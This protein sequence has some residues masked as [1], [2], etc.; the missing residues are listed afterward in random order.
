MNSK[1]VISLILCFIYILILSTESS[2]QVTEVKYMVKF[3]ESTELYDCYVVII[4]GFATT[5]QHRTQMSSQYSVVV[6]TGSIVT[7]PQTYLPLQ[8][9]QNYGGTVPSLWSLANQIL[10][11]AVQP[12]SDFYGIAP[13][14]VPAS[15]YNNITAGDTL[16]LFSLSIEVP[17]GGCKSSI[18]LFQN[19]IDPPAAAPGMGGGDFSNG[20][21]IG[22]PIQRY[23]G[24]FNGWIPADGVLNMADSGFGSLRKAVFCARENEYILVE[25]S[26]SGKTIQLLSPILIDK[27]INVVRSPNQ[28]FNIVAPIAG[29]AFVILQNKS[30][31]IK[32]LN[33]LAPHNSISQSRIF[34]N[35]GKL[36]VHNVDI[37]DPKLGQGAGSSITNLGEL[38]YE[39]SNTISD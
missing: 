8:N 34:T 20:F 3:N 4:A 16:K 17:Q 36:T 27:N 19:G 2:G 13:S 32:N 37:I 9:N 33:L 7:L 35:N 22:S 18:R 15:H 38:I 26:L 5:T 1:S 21:T 29:S 24:N 11:P 39:G 6:P 23:K 10:H 28:E 25:D 31:Y 14:L 30:L 12:N